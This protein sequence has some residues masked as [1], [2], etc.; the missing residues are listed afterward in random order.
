MLLHFERVDDFEAKRPRRPRGRLRRAPSR[1]FLDTPQFS[2]RHLYIRSPVGFFVVLV[3]QDIY[4]INAKDLK[5]I[6]RPF[7]FIHVFP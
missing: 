3:C 6:S 7:F 1:G 5:N 2:Y 4:E